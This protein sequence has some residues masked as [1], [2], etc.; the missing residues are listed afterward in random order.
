LAD[1]GMMN[2]VISAAR[3]HDDLG[4][5]TQRRSLRSHLHQRIYG[6]ETVADAGFSAKHH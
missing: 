1:L 6:T 4:W 3:V 5:V 2:Q